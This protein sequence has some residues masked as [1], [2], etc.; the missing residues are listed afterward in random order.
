MTHC[1][2]RCEKAGALLIAGLRG[3]FPAPFSEGISAQWER[4]GP[5]VGKIPG[6][7][8]PNAYGLC[9]NRPTGLDYLSGVE[10]SSEANAAGEFC[11]VTIPAQR[12]LVFRHPE[13]ISTLRTTIDNIWHKWLPEFGHEAAEPVAGAPNFFE[14]Y[15]EGFNPETGKGDIEVWIPIR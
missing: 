7:V 6:Q 13:H 4:F 10:V 2:P 12:Y 5:R 1:E 3:H 9:F 8:G 11:I 14:R 15:G